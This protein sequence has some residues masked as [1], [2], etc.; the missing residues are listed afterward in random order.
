MPFIHIK[1][2]PHSEPKDM[3]QI[4]INICHDF[5]HD[6]GISL[7]HIHIT[8]EFYQPGFYAN[9]GV[10]FNHQP[11][12]THPIIID[13]LTPDFNDIETVQKML[14]S[15]ANSLSTRAEVAK[16]NIF[17][18]HREA[19]SGLVYDEGEIVKW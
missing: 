8:C 1:S 3:R 14:I 6:T 2:L 19:R 9:D 4:L 17:I 5:S 10:T 13:F 11:T 15:I 18:N 7:K 12:D 16:K